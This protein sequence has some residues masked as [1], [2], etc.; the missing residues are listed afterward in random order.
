MN[1]QMDMKTILQQLD[2]YDFEHLIADLWA[3]QGWET[4]VLQASNDR[5]IDVE[6]RRADPFEQKH[7]IQ[8]KRY[9]AGNNVGSK[10]AQQYASL[11]HQEEN[12]DAAVI[13]TTSGFT[14]Q[15][16]DVAADLNLK[17][18]DGDDLVQIIQTQDA[19]HLIDEYTSTQAD[20]IDTS[21][22]TN[23]PARTQSLQ[24][25]NPHRVSEIYVS[26]LVDNSI[27]NLVTENRLT[28]LKPGLTHSKTLSEQP[29]LGHL[30][31][32]EQPHFTF[33]SQKIRVPIE[34]VTRPA[35]NVYLVVTDHRILILIGEKDED[36]EITI[37]FRQIEDVQSGRLISRKI[38][39]KT[40]R[41][42]FR[43]NIDHDS[44]NESQISKDKDISQEVENCVQFIREA[45]Y[46]LM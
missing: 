25:L 46:S 12:V 28:K 10:E 13:V 4:R 31:K 6:A 18:I 45:V 1:R 8:A 43:F 32:D 30:Y 39:L 20:N 21:H 44:F 27:G 41:G 37:P 36:I 14:R 7:L 19:Q 16:E 29:I 34:G 40:E 38:G 5:G 15:A 24:T 3:D 33:N 2:D 9:S 17:L 42:V 11:R 22:H 26:K 35:N 23:E